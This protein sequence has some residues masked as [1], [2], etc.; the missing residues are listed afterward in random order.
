MRG[1]ALHHRE[2]QGQREGLKTERDDNSENERDGRKRER[3]STMRKM[4]EGEE[5]SKKG[6]V[7]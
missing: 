6:A 1:P 3:G 4:C 7:E 2:E 5:R